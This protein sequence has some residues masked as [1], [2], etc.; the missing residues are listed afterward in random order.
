MQA[1]ISFT[2]P[3]GVP[4][5]PSDFLTGVVHIQSDPVTLP[6]VVAGRARLPAVLGHERRPDI[7]NVPLRK[8]IY[9]AMDFRVWFG[10]FAPS[11]TPQSSVA[12]TSYAMNKVAADPALRKTLFAIA[13][14]PNPGT[15][16]RPNYPSA[17]RTREVW[18][19]YPP[20]QYNC[21]VAL[22]TVTRR[23]SLPEQNEHH[24]RN[25]C[26]RHKIPL[27]RWCGICLQVFINGRI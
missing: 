26:A 12:A 17:Q 19:V 15:P 25:G 24:S 7:P 4:A 22:T 27:E 20:V 2:C 3:T 9:P 13:M 6:H 16:E 8:E 18:S 21:A 23:L 10:I 14:A 11:R 5:N 1:S